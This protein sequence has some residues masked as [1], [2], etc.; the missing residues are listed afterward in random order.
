MG[1]CHP[2]RCRA[3]LEIHLE[4]TMILTF[5]LNFQLSLSIQR[6]QF[7]GRNSEGLSI[8]DEWF[9]SKFDYLLTLSE[10]KNEENLLATSTGV[11][12]FAGI[13][14]SGNIDRDFWFDMSNHC[15]GNIDQIVEVCREKD[16]LGHKNGQT[17][18]KRPSDPPVYVYKSCKRYS[19]QDCSTV[20]A[21]FKENWS[22]TNPSNHCSK[23][24]LS[25]GEEQY[26]H[27]SYKLFTDPTDILRQPILNQDSERS[28]LTF[29]ALIHNG[30]QI[31][32]NINIKSFYACLKFFIKSLN[33]G[34]YFCN[35]EHFIPHS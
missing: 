13:Y 8:K 10:N 12:E 11:K 14:R 24:T 29:P 32:P 19:P 5:F 25:E 23:I 20:Q 7:R 27:G 2:A 22:M 9:E 21:F 31:T 3:V 1:S 15:D 28:S 34:H 6:T 18:Y 33:S 4:L 17:F 26:C 30:R 35:E 16:W